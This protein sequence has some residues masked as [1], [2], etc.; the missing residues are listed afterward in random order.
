MEKWEDMIIKDEQRQ[1]Y[2]TIAPDGKEQSYDYLDLE[3]FIR[4]QAQLTWDKTR[5]ET[6]QEIFADIA[7]LATDSKDENLQAY[8]AGLLEYLNEKWGVK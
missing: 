6:A 8:V 1:K 5:Q 4:A 7:K 2:L 3:G